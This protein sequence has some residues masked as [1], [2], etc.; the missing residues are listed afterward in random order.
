MWKG[1][2]CA[3][4][5]TRLAS[6][7]SPWPPQIEMHVPFASLTSGSSRQTA[8]GNHA[9]ADCL[10]RRA[11][12]LRAGRIAVILRPR[13]TKSYTQAHRHANAGPLGSSLALGSM[14]PLLRSQNDVRTPSVVS[15]AAFEAKYRRA[16]DPWNFTAS[17]YE[18]D[19]YEHTLRSLTRDRYR[20]AFEPACSIG[21]LT[22][23]LAERCDYLTAIDIA[24][25]AVAAARERCASFPHVKIWCADLATMCPQGR[26]D[27]IVFSELGYYFEAARLTRIARSLAELLAPGGELLGVHWLGS[28]D[29]HLLHGDEVHAILHAALPASCRWLKGARHPGF[30]LDTWRRK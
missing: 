13:C 7:A 14:V 27:L 8:H 16:G 30:R 15:Q 1:V 11:D 17:R 3:L 26:F 2:I 5:L 25:S 18:R 10:G 21:V 9:R 19:R 28:S 22:A 6:A 23:A 29:D 24:P 4:M 12:F 20:R